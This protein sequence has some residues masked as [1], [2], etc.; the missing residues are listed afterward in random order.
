MGA[1]SSQLAR[2]LARKGIVM[3][4]KKITFFIDGN[5]V[6]FVTAHP[7]QV[8]RFNLLMQRLCRYAARFNYNVQ[9]QTKEVE[10]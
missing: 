10:L 6:A 9:Y 8:D 4:A 5:E 2:R 1:G 7:S 3:K